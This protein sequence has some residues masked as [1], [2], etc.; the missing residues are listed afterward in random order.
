MAIKTYVRYE[1][2]INQLKI[3]VPG[4]ADLWRDIYWLNVTDPISAGSIV[5]GT[6]IQQLE[7]PSDMP[8]NIAWLREFYLRKPDDG[9]EIR[10]WSTPYSNGQLGKNITRDGHYDSYPE[11]FVWIAPSDLPAG[12]RIG[13]RGRAKTSTIAGKYM[14]IMDK[15]VFT[16]EVVAP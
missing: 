3:T 6:L 4:E 9:A 15:G 7:N 16:V 11:M 1:R 10:L 8:D 12:C 14:N 13:Y 2:A 5:R